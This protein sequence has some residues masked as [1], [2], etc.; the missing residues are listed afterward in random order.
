LIGWKPKSLDP[1]VASARIRCMNP[2]GELQRRGY[3]VEL[4]RPDHASSYQAVVYSKLYDA[5]SYNEAR[6]L[7]AQGIRVVV[8]LCDNHFYNPA[9]VPE[10]AQAGAELR[11]M[12]QLADHLVASTPELAAV[13]VAE[14][15]GNPPVTV[16]GDAVEERI[17]GAEHPSLRRW[18]HQRR[19]RRL[20]ARLEQGRAAGVE[21]SLV[22]FGIHGGPHHD[23]GMADLQR[24][25]PIV[26]TIHRQHKLQLTV[27]SNSRSKFASL[28]APWTVPTH[29]LEWSPATFLDALRAHDIALIPVTQ[30]PFT[31]CKSNNRLATALSVGL[32]VVADSIPSYREFAEMCRLDDWRR[33]LIDYVNDPDLRR[34][35]ST[36]GRQYVLRKYSLSRIAGDW[37]GLF[38]TIT[39]TPV[40]ASQLEASDS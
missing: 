13:M 12:L 25:R 19:L 34:R 22:W 37:E 24:V 15:G 36:E 5:A 2:L 4:F 26:E 1:M 31:R 32:A 17:T 18:V 20:L 29:Y 27:I 10:L 30:N 3:P 14:A 40:P 38:R 7:R 23:H 16:I 35:H 28:I 39:A 8:D 9:N 21:T 6:R 11:R 33:G